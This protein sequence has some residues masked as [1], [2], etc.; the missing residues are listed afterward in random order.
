MLI[1]TPV[2]PRMHEK[3]EEPNYRF[4]WSRV[5][6]QNRI[7]AQSAYQLFDDTPS[8]EEATEFYVVS[9][10]VGV[11]SNNLCSYPVSIVFG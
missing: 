11:C 7:R 4:F 5:Y 10:H 1:V 6:S 3:N 8:R 2:S 9:F